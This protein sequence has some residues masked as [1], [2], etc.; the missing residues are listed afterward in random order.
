MVRFASGVALAGAALAAIL[1][2]PTL[3]L[4]VLACAV[5]ARAAFEYLTLV[6]SAIRAVVLAVA[7]CWVFSAASPPRAEVL[8]SMALLWVVAEVLVSNHS[9]QSA[10]AG[11]L[12]AAYVGMPLGMLVAVHALQGWRATLLLL[13]TV[14][15]S[16]TA[17]YYAGRLVGRRKL[18]PAI[19]P[20]KTIEGAVGGGVFG[21]SFMALVGRQLLPSSAPGDLVIL[22]LLVVLFGMAGD[23]FES[24]LKRTAGQKDSAALIPGHGG[25]LDRI[26]ALLFAAVPFYLYI[27]NLS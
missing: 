26:D 20:N 13:G 7:L 21:T 1:L 4:R 25:L 22:G 3:A 17:Q 10:A 16:D 6:D 9:V 8:L 23:L 27:R 15:V 18:A 2:L 14:V 11:V 12:G 5:A 24:R 19:S